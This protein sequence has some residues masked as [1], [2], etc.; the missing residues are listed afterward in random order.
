V[1]A[2]LVGFAAFAMGARADW[3]VLTDGTAV[4]IACEPERRGRMLV[5]RL[6]AGGLSSIQASEVDLEASRR[7][8]IAEAQRQAEAAEASPQA[9]EPVEAR[10]AVL[11][12]TD[13]DVRHIS[14]GR[15]DGPASGGDPEVGESEEPSGRKLVVRQWGQ[16]QSDT[17]LMI[18]G[19][20]ENRDLDAAAAIQLTI[21]ALDG[22]GG[23]VAREVAALDRTTLLPGASTGFS[24]LFEEWPPPIF[25]SVDFDVESVALKSGRG[26]A[27]GEAL[28][29]LESEDSPRL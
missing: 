4:E 17:G 3:L 10:E 23:E 5:F 2:A 20:L 28:P 29:D 11:V 26:E 7:R 12:L 18:F 24:V 25:E 15:D 8:T 14:D 27:A 6:P 19:V 16:E 13:A 1:V 22:A 21:V 9:P